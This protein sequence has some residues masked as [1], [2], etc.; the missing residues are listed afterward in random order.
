MASPRGKC[1][2]IVIDYILSPAYLH[3]QN[4]FS[5]DLVRRKPLKTFKCESSFHQTFLRITS[6]LLIANGPLRTRYI[7]LFFFM[8]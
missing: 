3:R 7:K 2:A 4:S 5:L 6:K 8:I 1:H